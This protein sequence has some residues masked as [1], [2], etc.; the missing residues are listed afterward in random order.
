MN[1]GGTSSCARADGYWS[2][3]GNGGWTPGTNIAATMVVGALIALFLAMAPAIFRVLQV[4]A[5]V[6]VEGFTKE[7]GQRGTARLERKSQ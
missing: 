3:T 7:S 4:T 5:H 2:V 1:F 6:L